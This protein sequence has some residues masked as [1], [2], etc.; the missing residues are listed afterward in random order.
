MNENGHGGVRPGAGRKLR[1]G[2]DNPVVAEIEAKIIG[3]LPGI[4]DAL[5][6]KAMA[7]NLPAARYLCD[8]ILGRVRAQRI[9]KT[10]DEPVI[11]SVHSADVPSIAWGNRDRAT[12]DRFAGV[13]K[14]LR[15]LDPSMS[16]AELADALV[17]GSDSPTIGGR[18]AEDPAAVG[19]L[20]NR[21]ARR[22]AARRGAA[23]VA[24]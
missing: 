12:P 6:E 3:A 4:V 13:L 14:D 11:P 15:R 23:K 24:A 16:P 20:A 1:Q 19:P 22:E 7:G 21:K 10:P 9:D 5:I 2:V 17:S 8:R 18:G